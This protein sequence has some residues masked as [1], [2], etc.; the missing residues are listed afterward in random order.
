M[1]NVLIV[2]DEHLVRYG[3]K[4]M[5][6]WESIGFNVVGEAGNG[7]DG[8][9]AFEELKPDVVISDIKMPIMDGMEFIAEVRSL[10]RQVKLILLTC[11]ED[12]DYAQKAMRLGTTDYLIK[13]DMMPKDL[14]EVMLKLK[15]TLDEERERSGH[16]PH[17]QASDATVE[18]IAPET[19]LLGLVQG[20]MSSASMTEEKLHASGLSQLEGKLLL[21]HIKVDYL[22]Q[23][24]KRLAEGDMLLLHA[25]GAEAVYEACSAEGYVSEQFSGS[26]GEWNMLLKDVEDDAAIRLGYHIVNQFS[27]VWNVSVTVSVSDQFSS[28]SQLR[29]AYAQAEERY[30]LKLFLGCGSVISSTPGPQSDAGSSPTLI[31][32]KRLNEYLY[33]LDKEAMKEYVTG[34]LDDTEASM[35]YDRA[36][37]IA[38]ELLLN[39]TAMY[40]ELTN[41]HEWLYERKKELYDQIKE[42]ETLADMKLWFIEV[43]EELIGKLRS[44][45]ASDQGAVPKVI[46]Y[47]EQH[48]TQELSLQILSQ[49]VHLSKNY[50]ANLF[51]KET[52]EG[53]IDYINKVRLERAKALL[54]ST[55]M[56]S[57]EICVM[58]G[59]QDSKYFSKLFKKMEGMTPSEYREMN[60]LYARSIIN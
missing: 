20:T 50:L 15:S 8:L 25:Q 54:R 4:A 29:N 40:S 41:D 57:S 49:H 28:L 10:D 5:I 7:K 12:F 43:Y 27:K 36:Q 44:G 60:R 19:L 31:T 1:Y 45:Y 17:A 52:G 42:L 32:S 39:L 56:K 38:I 37:L 11:L 47:I 58:V 59:V 22:E 53:V 13:S 24:S 35:D 33:S 3:I 55:E 9:L 26:I 34:I 16:T 48:Y 30:K 6:D 14:E 23:L 51:K 46:A 18:M 2:D 21:L